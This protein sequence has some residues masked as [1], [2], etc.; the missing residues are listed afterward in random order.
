MQSRTWLE[1]RLFP[2]NE[3]RLWELFHENSKTARF[4]PPKTEEFVA[5]RLAEMH[6]SL[7]YENYEETALP[8]RSVTSSDTVEEIIFSRRTTMKF[9]AR[10]HVVVG[11]IIII[12]NT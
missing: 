5:Q 7:T 6:E 11:I 10:T 4:E 1:L 8:D 9:D 12:F 3:R 2:E